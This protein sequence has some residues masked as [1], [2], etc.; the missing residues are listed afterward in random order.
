MP[1]GKD[2]AESQESEKTE[3]SLQTRAF[4]ASRN[5]GGNWLTASVKSR[6]PNTK[7]K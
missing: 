6:T 1:D 5:R 4:T 3:L 7:V 2:I